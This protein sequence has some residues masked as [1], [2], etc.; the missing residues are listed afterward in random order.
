MNMSRFWTDAM[1]VF[2]TASAAPEGAS[3]DLAVVIDGSGGLLIVM[4][5]GWT[6]EALR[7]AY[8]GRAVYQVTRTAQQVRLEGRAPGMSCTLRRSPSTT[9]VPPAAGISS[10]TIS[11]P[12]LLS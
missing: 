4:E 11:G 3:P 7:A 8:G 9:P 10:Y 1:Q 6:P 12:K 2:E 5:P